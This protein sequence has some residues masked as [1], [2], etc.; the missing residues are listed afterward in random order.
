MPEPSN[1]APAAGGGPNAV[2]VTTQK[3]VQQQVQQ[4]NIPYVESVKINARLVQNIGDIYK[5]ISNIALFS[6]QLNPDGII[7]FRV[8]SRDLQK[9]PFLFTILYFNKDSI[10]I[11]YSIAFDASKKLR[12]LSIMKD[13]L[14]IL[15]IITDAYQIETKELFRH[16]DSMIEDVLNSLSQ[17]Y[18]A[19]FNN[20][21]AMFN[22]YNE[23]KKINLDLAASNKSLAASGMVIEQKNKE[24][25]E[26]LKNLEIYSDESLM[27][28]VEEWI[29]AHGNS[30]DINEFAKNY[31]LL[32]PRV[33][34]ILNKMV[35]LGYLELKG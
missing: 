28:M 16:L 6:A 5:S 32:P 15:S 4:E 30:I 21:D 27:I 13:F 11:K 17:N 18:S 7:M 12:R 33:E 14:G 9:K 10:E 23:L 34:Q 26:K 20:Y 2:N 29:E 8:E 31:K 35:S 25:A 22:E 19:L 3:A 1:A 24:L